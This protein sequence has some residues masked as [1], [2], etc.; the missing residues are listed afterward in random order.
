MSATKTFQPAVRVTMLVLIA[1][2]S[3]CGL[4]PSGATPVPASAYNVLTEQEI[5]AALVT[6]A[7][8]AVARLRPR[9]LKPSGG[10]N[11]L[12]PA[13]YLNGV[14]IGGVQELGNIQAVSIREVRF[15]NAVEATAR[16]G[17]SRFGGALL[18][19]TK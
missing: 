6:T 2:V 11:S 10:T 15:L 3:A 16:Y 7:F 18:V 4:P 19:T 9:F 12:Q 13:I 5:S 1:T 8:D 14:L 17:A